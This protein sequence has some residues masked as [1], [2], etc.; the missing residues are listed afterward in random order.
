MQCAKAALEPF[1][2]TWTLRGKPCPYCEEG[3]FGRERYAM[4]L[5]RLQETG[6]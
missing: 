3:M 2:D 5:G 1:T 6:G 4:S